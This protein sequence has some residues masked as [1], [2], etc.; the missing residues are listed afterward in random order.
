VK[1][2]PAKIGHFDVFRTGSEATLLLWSGKAINCAKEEI[3]YNRHRTFSDLP[4]RATT[5]AVTG[6]EA[7]TGGDDSTTG[8]VTGEEEAMMAEAAVEEIVDIDDIKR[9]EI[10]IGLTDRCGFRKVRRI[11]R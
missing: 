5:G 1:S 2:L 11:F 7:V 6:G 10:M 3:N 8:A 9:F 4:E